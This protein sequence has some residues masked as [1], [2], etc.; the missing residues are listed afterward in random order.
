MRERGVRYVCVCVCVCVC[1]WYV[2]RYFSHIFKRH[3]G[4]CENCFAFVGPLESYFHH[5][6]GIEGDLPKLPSN[7][8]KGNTYVHIDFDCVQVLLSFQNRFSAKNTA[9]AVIYIGAL[10]DV[11]SKLLRITTNGFVLDLQLMIQLTKWTLLQNTRVVS[12]T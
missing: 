5:A 1:V 3:A 8:T 7:H 9:V 4:V 11:N 12:G 6:F 2:Y 10:R